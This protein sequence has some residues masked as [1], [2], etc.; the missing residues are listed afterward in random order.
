[1]STTSSLYQVV[2]DLDKQ[3][4]PPIQ[5]NPIQF[6]SITSNLPNS[7]PYPTANDA[8]N[9]ILQNYHAFRIT[10]IPQTLGYIPN[11]LITTF[12][13]PSDT[14]AINTTPTNKTI[15][16]LTPPTATA[17]TRTAILFPTLQQLASHGILRG[18]RNETFPL[19]GPDGTAILEIERAASALFGI[20]TYGVQMLCYTDDKV[21]N[22]PHLWIAKRSSLKQTYPGMLD[23]TAAG[24]LSTGLPPREAIMREASEEAEIPEELLRK[25]IRFVD[26]I[27]Y[28]HVKKESVGGIGMVELLQPEVEYLYELRLGKEV[29]P[30]PADSEVEDFRLWGVKEVKKAL[31]EGRFKPNSAVVVVDFLL[32]RGLLDGNDEDERI[33]V[34]LHRELP[35]PVVDHEVG[36]V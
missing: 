29:V 27:S 18:W 32:R 17:S 35:L 19:Y 9:P 24:G 33:R 2:A 22:T 6:N 21:S 12:P 4:Y 31:G 23:T 5:S 34:R 15:T 16:L 26:R 1:M 14:W 28:F 13:W 30:S 8:D 36:R 25:E 3:V 7:F 10:G 11:E 20:V